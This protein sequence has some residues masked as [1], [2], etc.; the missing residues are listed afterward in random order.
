MESPCQT[1]NPRSNSQENKKKLQTNAT[2]TNE[3]CEV[4]QEILTEIIKNGKEP[5]EES[6]SWLTP[7]HCASLLCREEHLCFEEQDSDSD[8]E[9]EEEEDKGRD[10]NKLLYYAAI[11]SLNS[12]YEKQKKKQK[13]KE[14]KKKDVPTGEGRDA[15]S[16][17]KQR[18][19]RRRRRRR[20]RNA[21]ATLLQGNSQ[22]FEQ[23][24]HSRRVSFLFSEDESSS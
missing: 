1:N 5:E 21:A 14:R 11:H 15:A 2:L 9:P 23:M 13:Q 16:L 3:L 12:N 24:E 17:T 8:E 7:S 18:R 10:F 19:K 6:L 20:R 22:S 4:L